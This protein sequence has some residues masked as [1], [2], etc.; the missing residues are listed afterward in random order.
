MSELDLVLQLKGLVRARKLLAVQGASAET[1]A[2]QD[3]EIVRAHEQL[4]NEV[5]KAGTYLVAA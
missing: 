1:L 2:A 4:A 3:A 5:R